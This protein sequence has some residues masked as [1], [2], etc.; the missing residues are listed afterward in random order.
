MGLGMITRSVN[1]IFIN[2]QFC[3]RSRINPMFFSFDTT[4]LEADG[5][6][7]FIMVPFRLLSNLL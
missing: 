2:G 1:S 7:D 3:I 6:S 5:Y 4:S